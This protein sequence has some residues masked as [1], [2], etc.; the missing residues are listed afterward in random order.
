MNNLVQRLLLF[1]LGIPAIIAL[2]VFLPQAK[3]A[4]AVLII[5]SFLGGGGV[6]LAQIFKDRGVRVKSACTSLLGF[7]PALA[8][9]LAA[10]LAGSSTYSVLEILLFS[11]ALLALVIFTPFAFVRKE[12]ISEVTARSSAYGLAL[13]YPG[14]LGAFIVL[15]AS[16]P[17]WATESLLTFVGLTLGNDSLAWFFGMTMGRK[18]GLVAVSPNKSLAGFIGGM[19]GS[20]G[21][22][23]V[24]HAFFPYAM[25]TTWPL[26]VCLGL[27]VGA[28][29]IVGDLFESAL[30]RSA[31]TKD[32]GSA[33]PGRGGFLDSFDSIIFAAPVFYA[34]SIIFGL[35]R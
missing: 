10:L 5:L 16:E 34:A 21:L 15:V 27:L 1:F 8:T 20:V 28:A 9:Y 12:T 32:S 26:L 11:I 7:L 3:H 24:A 23:F 18:R 6:E 35:F 19:V 17:R 31:G 33:V 30:K 22:A 14:M 13:I 29:V 4:L 25:K 2:I